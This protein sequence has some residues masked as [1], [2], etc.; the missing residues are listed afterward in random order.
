MATLP[1]PATFSP[2]HQTS[3]LP[4]FPAVDVS[5]TP[6][7]AVLSPASG[8]IGDVHF[9]P[10]DIAK[11]IGG[12]TFYLISAT[13]TYF[14]TH[15]GGVTVRSGQTVSAGQQLGTVGAV[16]Q[17]AWAAH[18]H[19]GFDPGGKAASPVSG[20]AA[21]SSAGSNTFSGWEQAILRGI[22]APVNTATIAFLDAWHSF[23][24][25]GATNNPLNTTQ[26]A[27]GASNFNSAGVKNY[28]NASIGASA[29]TRTLLNGR[30]PNVLA[31]LRSGNPFSYFIAHGSAVSSQ[32]N[33]WGS[34]NF[35]KFLQ[36]GGTATNYPG[37]N[38][39]N[40]VGQATQAVADAIGGVGS[41]LGKLIDP[42]NMLRGLQIVAGG[43]LVLVGIYL[44]AR[45][46][47]LA[48][49]APSPVQQAAAGVPS[50]A[51]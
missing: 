1:L 43:V 15:F 48:F 3:G 36:G 12:F 27:S 33:T 11:R 8:T 37:Q 32:L 35:A 31:A 16:P 44:L 51:E 42:H 22:G 34:G 14:L 29:T 4:G 30:Y 49:D 13:G 10:W 18:I 17:N 5:G 45:Q 6:G 24:Q 19:E 9:I 21:P 38:I 28:P 46:V 47:G 2:T 20:Q 41:F 23:E 39:V 25:S 7:E 40:D 26:T 50:V